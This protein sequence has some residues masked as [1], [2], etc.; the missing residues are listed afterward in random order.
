MVDISRGE[1]D[2]SFPVDEVLGSIAAVLFLSLVLLVVGFK[3]RG[4]IKIILYMK[5]GMRPFDKKDDNIRG[6]VSVEYS[7]KGKW[8]II[9][10]NNT[11]LKY[12]HCFV[13]ITNYSFYELF[14][15]L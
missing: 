1:L 5:L 15:D 3:F 8:L 4:E 7:W 13:I 9:N 11:F 14:Y 10:A 2:C 12:L 6:K